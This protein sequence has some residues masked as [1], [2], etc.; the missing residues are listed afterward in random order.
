MSKVKTRM[1]FA[2]GAGLNLGTEYSP[3][4]DS[5]CFID[6]SEANL[7]HRKISSDRMYVIPNTDGAGGD[8]SFMMP[9]ARKHAPAILE[10]F[11]PGNQNIIVTSGGGGT[12]PTVT[13]ALVDLL[14]KAEQ[15]VIVVVVG[16]YDATKRVRNTTN[17][18]KNLELL[19][20]K[21]QQ[22]VIVSYI[23]NSAGEAPANEE[24]Q[25]TLAA[26]DALTDQENERL[27]TK[28]LENFL[29]FNRVCPVPPQL[30]TLHIRETRAEAAKVLEPIM[31]IA[32][33][34][35]IALDVPYGSPFERKVGITT[36][37][38]KLPG[39]QMHF[40]INSVGVTDIFEDLEQA[41]TKL[42]TVQSGFR[43]RRS[44]FVAQD[45]GEGEDLFVS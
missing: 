20:L 14:L 29:H 32:L 2:G 12:G 43:Q 39:N 10:Q 1:Y 24:A 21:H 41:L 44:S 17:V 30:C 4:S 45:L 22:P 26:L 15:N 40:I 13:V 36:R 34:N 16:G 7:K 9:H 18:L 6:S 8:Q 42:N 37:A 25:F 27:D 38:D 19:S 5:V 11:E 35:D 33:V 3:N 23:S 31:V 28:D